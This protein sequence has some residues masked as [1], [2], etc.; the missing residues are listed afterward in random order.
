MNLLNG[1]RLGPYEID[2]PI[3]AGGMGAVFRARDTRLDRTVAIK[4]LPTELAANAQF[5]LRFDR[6]AK[7]ISSLNHPNICTLFDVGS[8]EVIGISGPETLHYLVMEHIEGETL[9][10][11]LARG[12]LPLDQV[13]RRG[14]E[15][16]DALDR[17]HRHGIIHR[18]LKPGNVMLTRSG[19]KLLDFGLAR[20]E[21]NDPAP[22]GNELTAQRPLTQEGTILGTWHYMAPEQLEGLR[23]DERSDIFAFG[24][25]LY[26]MATGRRAFDGKSRS[27]II[28]AIISSVPPPL[29]QVQPLAPPALEQIIARAIEKDPEE[30]WQSIRD[31]RSALQWIGDAGS[32]AGVAKAVVTARRASRRTLTVLAA[33]GWIAAIAGAAWIVAGRSSAGESAPFRAELVAAPERPLAAVVFGAVTL[34]PDGRHL[35]MISSEGGNRRLAVRDFATGETRELNGT[36]DA[37][38]PFWSP[39]GRSIAFFSDGKLKKVDAN[40]GPV[41]ILCE[42]HAGRGGSW[43]RSG[44]I[45]FAPDIQG[46]LMQVSENGGSPAPVTT[47]AADT[48]HRNPLFLSDGRRFLFI[49]RGS[50]TE[51]FGRI[52]LGTLGAPDARLVAERASNPQLARGYLLFVRDGNLVAQQFNEKKGAAEGTL[53]PIAT[54]IDYYN[55]RDV[56]NFSANDAGLLVYRQRSPVMQELAWYTR[57]GRRLDRVGEPGHYITGRL[58]QDGRTVAMVRSDASASNYDIWALDLERQQMTRST[59]V[60][61]SGVIRVVPSPDGQRLA[62]SSTVGSA[63][64]SHTAWLQQT[65]GSSAG[66]PLIESSSFLV[67]DWSADGKYIVGSRQEP[68]SGHDVIWFSVEDPKNIR[69]FA[70]TRFE[71]RSARFSPDGK[72]LAWTSDESGQHEV[73]VSDFPEGKRKWQVSTAGAG[74]PQWS[75]DGKE[76]LMSTRSGID[77][78]SFEQ[79]GGTPKFNR[80]VSLSISGSEELLGAELVGTAGDRLLLLKRIRTDEQPLRLVRNWEAS[81]VR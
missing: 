27:S 25:L 35:A 31:V 72:W 51:A 46:P 8:S 3:G 44:L 62:I 18:D 47:A 26:E 60:A 39:D 16:A 15:I 45:V 29:S 73:Y 70:A 28:A 13:I 77:S 1:T 32:Q 9:A 12:P 30:R 38:F 56:A 54:S 37:A 71:E 79:S 48:T 4:V 7:T 50:R 74:D 80:P 75:S 66:E 40:G 78:A 41:Q 59:F 6:E 58:S 10:D 22:E 5:R 43:G 65:S 53:L 20:Q 14:C 36:T 63:W 49:E 17:A 24:C 52:M 69:P 68:N 33:A 64:G 21:E 61:T 76:L 55:A 2:A 42:A 57:D 67:S 34:S 23:A 11:R 19:V 81:L